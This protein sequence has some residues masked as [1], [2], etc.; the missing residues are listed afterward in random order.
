MT[1]EDD[2]Y[3]NI[4][5]RL[6]LQ[7]GENLLTNRAVALAELVKNSYDADATHVLVNL[8]NIKK[9]GGTIVVNDNGSGM[10]LSTF[11]NTWMRIA[12]I[13]KENNPISQKYKRQ[14]AGEK[15]IGRF[16]CRRLSNKLRIKSVAITEDGHKEELSAF[17]DWTTFSPGSD[18]DKIPVKYTAKPVDDKTSIGTTLFLEDTKDSWNASDIKRLRNEL[19]DLISPTTFKIGHE[20]EE[21]PNEYDPG[22]NVDLECP[23]FPTKEE[24]LDSTFLKNAWAKLSGNVD[25][26]GHVTYEINV[27]NKI[28]NNINKNFERNEVFQYLKNAQLEI[29]LFVYLPN[30]FRGSEWGMSKAAEIGRDRGGIKVYAD[31]FRVFGYGEK[32][33][34]WLKLDYDRARS[35]SGVNEEVS[36]YLEVEDR[37]GLR[38]F[39]NRAVFGHVTFKRNSNPTLEITV[40][41]E[42]LIGNESF[43]DLTKFVRLGVDFATVL[44]SNEVT[45][46]RY[47]DLEKEKVEEE[48]RKKAEEELK[49]KAENARIKAEELTKKAEAERKKAEERAK[50]VE[51]ERK[52]A[53][54]ELR[55]VEEERRDAEINRRKAEEEERKKLDEFA[56]QR[57][58]EALRK[59]KE[60][61]KAEEEARKKEEERRR[62]EEEVRLKTEEE[63][64]KSEKNRLQEIEEIRK[65][66][67]EIRKL[68]DEE[69]K[70]K[71]EKYEIESSQLRV[72]AS[73]GTLVLIINHELRALIESMEEMNNN[74]PLIIRKMPAE[75]QFNYNEIQATFSDRIEMVKEFGSLAGLMVGIEGREKREW[76]ILPI[77]ESVF[78]PFKWYLNKFGVEY[79]INMPDNLRTQKM[80]RSEL[81]S[82]LINLMSNAAKA[83]IGMNDRRIEVKGFE[84]GDYIHIW[85]LDSGRGLDKS[86]WEEV[87]EPFVSY[88]EPDLKFG[89]GTGLGLKIVSDI[90]KACGGNVQ[91]IN[92]PDDWK[93]CIEVMLPKRE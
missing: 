6:L 74:F 79:S 69:I 92:P 16:A 66:E 78:R 31:N 7:L 4:D 33:D 8:T 82:V 44:Y 32:G 52:R 85:F 86:L 51:S 91:F 87:F 46:K 9:P 39:M 15:G 48:E 38:L 45:K 81:V 70:R 62:K 49:K 54:E 57:L 5:S 12:T 27:I 56:K 36:G 37:P 65:T 88:S 60:L 90:I 59:E 75:E 3:F 1:Q 24:R 40:N 77:I 13:D 50:I 22:F 17:F 28:L 26:N 43:E 18:V 61:L 68:K 76:V 73:T 71:E 11:R 10:P 41:R 34:D 89:V 83:V 20:F 64:K 35:I 14:K 47:F 80:Y 84:E 29:Y 21:A 19:T 53:E 67:D 42:R 72:L 58:D 23:E 30:F 63:R 25:E 93:T 2:L 55:K